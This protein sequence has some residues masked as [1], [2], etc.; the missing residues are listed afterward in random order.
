[1]NR[2]NHLVLCVTSAGIVGTL[3]VSSLVVEYDWPRWVAL[4]VFF[5]VAFGSFLCGELLAS[6]DPEN[7][8][9]YRV[10]AVSSAATLLVLG[11]IFGADVS[12]VFGD[13]DNRLVFAGASVLFF[14]GGILTAR[15]Y[16]RI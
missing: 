1:M 6:R 15:T 3:A 13:S 4:L 2:G 16:V 5:V 11:S 10:V 7:V 9:L 14:L 12:D 8:M